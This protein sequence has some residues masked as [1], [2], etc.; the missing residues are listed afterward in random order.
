MSREHGRIVIFDRNISGSSNAEAKTELEITV[1]ALY[2]RVLASYNVGGQV[3]V[4]GEDLRVSRGL[5]E[6]LELMGRLE[7]LGIR[8]QLWKTAGEW[9]DD[10]EV[11]KELLER[12]V[13]IDPP[14]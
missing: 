9:K 6:V 8:Q 12:R 1:E 7:T 3:V 5:E 11:Q 10:A 14:N 4:W 2:F 13:E